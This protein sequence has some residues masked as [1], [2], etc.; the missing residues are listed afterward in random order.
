[1]SQPGA[2]LTAPVA[3]ASSRKNPES[4]RP[5][6]KG[7]AKPKLFIILKSPV[8]PRYIFQHLEAAV[9]GLASHPV[10]GYEDLHLLFRP[11]P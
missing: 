6:R 8:K 1:M 9:V 5:P 11:E 4:P 7:V 2:T 3:N 10:A